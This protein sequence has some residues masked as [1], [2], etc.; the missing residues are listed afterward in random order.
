LYIFAERRKDLQKKNDK[1]LD[2]IVKKDYNN[3]LEKVLEKKYFKENVKNL[4][5]SILYKV[6]TAY[7]DYE[8]VKQ[9]V[10]TKDEFI[11]NIIK[12]VKENCETIKLV[13]PHSEESKIIGNRTFLVEEKKKRIICYPIERKLLYCL[14]KISNN[15]KIIKDNYFL[16]DKTLSDLINVGHNINAVESIRDFNGYS[17]TTIPR[18]LESITHNLIYQNIRILVGNQFLNNWINNNEYI[19]DYMELFKE[20][21]E[22]LYGKKEYTKFLQILEGL[23]VLIEAKFDINEK[24][25]MTKIKNEIENKLYEVNNSHIFIQKMTNDKIKLTN[26]IKR[27]D[28]TIND[29]NML[30]EEYLKRN[31]KLPLEEKIFSIRILSKLMEEERDEKIIQLEKVNKLL[32]PNNFM[33]YKNELI[34]KDKYLKLLNTETLDK[35]INIELIKLQKEFLRCYIL[36]LNKIETKQQMLKAIYEFR[37][38]NILPFNEKRAIFEIEHL[39]EELDLIQRELIKKAGQ[40]KIMNIFSKNEETNYQIVKNIFFIRVINLETLYVK[41]TRDKEKYFVQLFDDNVFEE[42][43]EIYVENK[44]NLEIRFNKKVKIFI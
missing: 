14:N 42:K 43:Q 10:E 31:E 37:Y 5:L 25:K 30:Q 36:K 2:K 23:S 17:W 21:F 18:E 20:R 22:T 40:L 16:I 3:E 12:N 8:K 38:Y 19:I 35:D 13:Q 9:D 41:V 44:R 1:F 11:Q 32:M 15:E 26:E 6:E 29:K 7:N 4:L 39:K 33:K 34:Y 27:I 24:I 28:E